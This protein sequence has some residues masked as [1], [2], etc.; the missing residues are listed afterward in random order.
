MDLPAKRR[1]TEVNAALQNSGTPDRSNGGARDG[2]ILHVQRSK[3]LLCE[4]FLS[5][6]LQYLWTEHICNM[7]LTTSGSPFQMWVLDS[8]RALKSLKHLWVMRL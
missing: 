7:A 1:D 5:G 6:V 2:I 3:G 4:E 8:M